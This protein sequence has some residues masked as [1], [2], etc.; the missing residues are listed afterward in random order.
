MPAS[1]ALSFKDKPSRTKSFASSNILLLV[2][3]IKFSWER[4]EYLTVLNNS[5]FSSFDNLFN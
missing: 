1:K 5:I 4:Y 3:L 2:K